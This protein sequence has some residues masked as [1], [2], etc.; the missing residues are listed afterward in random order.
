M[1]LQ[2]CQN[3]DTMKGT[4]RDIVTASYV[5]AS[6][7]PRIHKNQSKWWK[8]CLQATLKCL[9]IDKPG[10]HSHCSDWA[11][12]WMVDALFDPQQVWEICLY[13]K[14][15][16]TSSIALT[17]AP[18]QWIQTA[19]SSVVSWTGHEANLSPP[20]YTKVKNIWSYTSTP[21]VHLHGSHRNSFTITSNDSLNM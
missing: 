12:S 5:R 11:T 20:P 1:H 10:Q 2:C 17:Q 15:F 3:C 19:L 6:V 18:I 8:F 7:L 14:T 21:T 4:Y 16:E 13:C 9:N